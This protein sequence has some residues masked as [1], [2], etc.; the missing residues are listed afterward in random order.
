MPV[1]KYTCPA[2]TAVLRTAA[3]LPAGKLIRCPKCS[4]VFAPTGKDSAQPKPTSILSQPPPPR[5]KDSRPAISSASSRPKETQLNRPPGSKPKETQ[6]NQPP[7]QKPK[8]TQLQRPAEQKSKE[9]KLAGGTPEKK[10]KETRLAAGPPAKKPQEPQKPAGNSNDRA[11]RTQLANG[12]DGVGTPQSRITCPNCAVVLKWAGPPPVGK[13]IKCPKCTK[14]FVLGKD[15]AK[16]QAAVK[17]Q[18]VTKP[19]ALV[20]QIPCPHCRAKLKT[21][22]PLPIGK[23]IRCPGCTKTFVVRPPSPPKHATQLVKPAAQGSKQTKLAP[24]AVQQ[25]PKGTQ[26]VPASGKKTQLADPKAPVFRLACPACQAVLT[27]KKPLPAG[28]AIRCPGCRKGLRLAARPQVQP[29]KVRTALKAG[30]PPTRIAKSAPGPTKSTSSVR[31]RSLTR[32]YLFAAFV[33]VGLGLAFI[34]VLANLSRHDIPESAW[35]PFVLPNGGGQL[36]LPGEPTSE[37][38][39]GRGPGVIAAQRFEVIRAEEDVLFLLLRTDRAADVTQSLT[40]AEFYAPERDYL[41]DKAPG[42]VVQE[43]DL[44]LNGHPGKE[45]QVELQAKGMMIAR[46]YLVRGQPRDRGYVLVAI[47][48]RLQPGK[49]DAARFFDSFKIDTPPQRPD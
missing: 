47:G 16:P 29:T 48:R 21:S 32:L 1:I 30:A 36:L 44:T 9:T 40:F 19:Q 42:R 12:K 4:K 34:F 24:K 14:A 11:K 38:V 28:V 7:A 43:S 13:S 46:T 5:P 35:Q 25:K 26:L 6:L 20:H 23:T 33:C 3:P 15:V 27:S 39:T 31:H 22:G 10:S 8:G 45:L 17:P 2:C 18:A 41:L 37:A 49:G